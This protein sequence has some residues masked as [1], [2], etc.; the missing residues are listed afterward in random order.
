MAKRG[1][2]PLVWLTLSASAVS[3]CAIANKWSGV[4]QAQQLHASGVL[5]TATVVKIWDTGMTVNDD[6]VV[7][8]LL[9]VRPEDRPAYQAQTKMLISRLAIP[10]IQPGAVVTVRYDPVEPSRVSLDLGALTAR[11]V[12]LPAA[13]P[14]PRAA[15]LEAEKQRLLATG[16]AG[17]ATILQCQSL[18]LFDGDGR[19]VYDLLLLIEVPGQGPMQGPARVGVASE[20]EHWFKVGQRLPVRADPSQPSHV[21]VD[22]ER[23]K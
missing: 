19:P 12:S 3:G 16:L 4:T 1:L 21:A 11:S 15:D 14:L 2:R 6:P 7:G 9:E 22:W 8:F 13:T 10:Q 20:R 23:V 5:A 17:T 18:G